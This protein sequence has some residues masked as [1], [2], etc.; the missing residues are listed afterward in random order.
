MQKC[1]ILLVGVTQ[2][3]WQKKV[4]AFIGTCEF[5]NIDIILI[6]LRERSKRET[7]KL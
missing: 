2:R 7:G 3:G 4:K 1:G 6:L 5:N